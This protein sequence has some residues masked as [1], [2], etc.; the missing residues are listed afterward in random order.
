MKKRKENFLKIS[1]DSLIY[2]SVQSPKSGG[3]GYWIFLKQHKHLLTFK[4]NE[5]GAFSPNRN[6]VSLSTS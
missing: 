6:S 3:Q 5:G 1:D 2:Q 4:N